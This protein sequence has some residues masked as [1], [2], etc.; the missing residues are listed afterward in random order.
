MLVGEL[1]QRDGLAVAERDVVREAVSEYGRHRH[2]VPASSG[3]AECIPSSGDFDQQVPGR[4]PENLPP[5][6]F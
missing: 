1:D 5:S 3:Q 6:R 4:V 2:R